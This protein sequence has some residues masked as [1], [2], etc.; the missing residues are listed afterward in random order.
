MRLTYPRSTYRDIRF[1]FIKTGES[2]AFRQAVTIP[3][4]ARERSVRGARRA[5]LERT[6]A[7]FERTYRQGSP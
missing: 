4:R 2:L 6:C 7:R 5:R 1:C 3:A